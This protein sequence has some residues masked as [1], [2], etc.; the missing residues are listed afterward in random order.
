M[1]RDLVVYVNTAVQ[2]MISP[3]RILQDIPMGS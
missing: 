3:E 1:N 2:P